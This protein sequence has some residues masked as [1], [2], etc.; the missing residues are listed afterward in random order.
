MKKL[1]AIG[2]LLFC[3]HAL[4][5][6][7]TTST[8]VPVCTK[9]ELDVFH[10]SYQAEKAH[11]QFPT[12]E[13]IYPLNSKPPTNWDWEVKLKVDRNGAVVCYADTD[14]LE[15]PYAMNNEQRHLIKQVGTWH[16]A[17]F[18][19][20]GYPVDAIVHMRMA[21]SQMP[22]HHVP[23]PNVPLEK[24][25]ITLER[26]ACFGSCPS[27]QIDL[28]GD[29]R[30]SYRG[31][32]GVD[33]KGQH[34]YRIRKS[35]IAK[36]FQGIRKRDIWS[37]PSYGRNR[38]DDAGCE[39]T[40]ELNGATRQL[41]CGAGEASNF[42]IMAGITDEID[43][44]AQSD[45]WITL[46]SDAVNHL[47]AENFDFRSP[48]GATLLIRT[49]ADEQAHDDNVLLRLIQLG[50]PLDGGDYSAEFFGYAKGS[51]LEHALKN[52]RTILIDPLIAADF[53]N[54]NGT[55]DQ[56]KIDAAFRAAIR[57]G[58]FDLVKKIWQI[59]GSA[60]HPSL[61]FDPGLAH[62]TETKL[63]IPVTLLLEAPVD[64][65]ERWDGLEI[66]KWLVSMGCD[67]H[68][69]SD[70]AGTLLNIAVAGGNAQFVQYLLDAGLSPSSPEP[71]GGLPLEVA[72]DEDV[73][74]ALLHAGATVA[75]LGTG[76]ES[77]KHNAM[78]SDWSRVLAWVQ[79]HGE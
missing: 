47:K 27:Y 16:Y 5:S 4:A 8:E 34:L 64:K 51:L 56:G 53:L 24:V 71:G 75:Q 43:R 76:K 28:Y 67:I 19:K 52:R 31:D 58:R 7:S 30:V 61:T 10:P 39:L 46:S 23:I 59:A 73:A 69:T 26:T 29:G 44:I 37:I 22:E 17:P 68:A 70:D 66:A 62:R 15:N 55:L 45:M 42:H 63:R 72:D 33:V 13:I 21:E 35:E 6:Q 77:F 74:L 9:E 78:I 65:G 79:A 25:H 2:L 20:D 40:I 49:V 60:P 18:K 38:G 12:P 36:L 11:R 1:L 48:A 14:Y 32:S 57:G 54:T 50:A 41:N 3:T